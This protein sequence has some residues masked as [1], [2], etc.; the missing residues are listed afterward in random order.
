MILVRLW[1]RTDAVAGD[2]SPCATD[3]PKCLSPAVEVR[4]RECIDRAAEVISACYETLLSVC[5]RE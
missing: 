1:A 4:V 3:P 5:Y 2:F